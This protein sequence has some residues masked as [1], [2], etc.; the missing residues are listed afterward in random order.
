MNSLSWFLYFIGIS[1]ALAFFLGMGSFVL[2]AVAA[3]VAALQDVARQ[4]I[5]IKGYVF[6]SVLLA[7]LAV[8]IP[9]T[10]TMYAM[11]AS[12]FGQKMLESE[13]GGKAQEALKLWIDSQINGLKTK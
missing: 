11:V 5:K 10:N 7:V 4:K 1:K 8:L 9:P 12:E 13:I 2:A 3:V 6:A